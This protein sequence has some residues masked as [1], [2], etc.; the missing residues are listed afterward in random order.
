MEEKKGLV[1]HLLLPSSSPEHENTRDLTED[2]STNNSVTTTPPA[3]SRGASINLTLVVCVG[4]T[5][6]RRRCAAT[7]GVPADP[8]RLVCA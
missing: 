2:N 3:S 1:R 8:A 7:R 4:N 5:G 6:G